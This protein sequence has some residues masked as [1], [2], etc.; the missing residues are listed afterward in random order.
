MLQFPL[1]G[2]LSDPPCGDEVSRALGSFQ[3]AKAGGD[4]EVLPDLLK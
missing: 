4:N 2:L 1:R 3:L